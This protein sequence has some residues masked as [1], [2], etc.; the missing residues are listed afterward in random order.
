ERM[1]L[2]AALTGRDF[3]RSVSTLKGLSPSDVDLAQLLERVGLKAGPQRV[4]TFSKGMR[5]RLGLA[6]A[7]LGQPELLILDEPTDGIDP[8][9]RV[10]VRALLLEEK[11]RGATLLLN[12]H[13]LSETERICDRIGVLEKGQLRLEGTL[14]DV[15]RASSHWVVRF[16]GEPAR[17]EGFVLRDGAW[18][19]DGDVAGL[20]DALDAA[21]A[22]GL[23]ITAVVPQQQDLEAV[24]TSSLQ[25]KETT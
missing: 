17:V 10:E 24:L 25:S 21:R 23:R 19:F 18:T 15:R 3:L 22:S 7:M 8:V 11:K 5:Q 20:N 14:D 12:S 13:L 1:H 16:E 9:G 6:A 4:G 2:P